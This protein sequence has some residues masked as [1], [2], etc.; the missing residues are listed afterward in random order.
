M[1]V[2][3]WAVNIKLN[4]KPSATPTGSLG[5]GLEG[6]CDQ[7]STIQVPPLVDPSCLNRPVA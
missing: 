4:Q 7:L 1:V 6:I 5:W 2:M 3:S